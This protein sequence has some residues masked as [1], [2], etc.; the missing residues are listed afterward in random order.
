MQLTDG[1]RQTRLR[2][3]SDTARPATPLTFACLRPAERAAEAEP[4]YVSPDLLA[5]RDDELFAELGALFQTSGE[6]T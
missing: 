5:R 1:R 3:V 4:P 6:S 2:L